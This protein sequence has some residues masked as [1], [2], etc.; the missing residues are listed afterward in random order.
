MCSS[1]L[2][3]RAHWGWSPCFETSPEFPGGWKTTAPYRMSR[4][5]T[6]RSMPPS[7]AHGLVTL[8]RDL[9]N[10]LEVLQ[11][12]VVMRDISFMTS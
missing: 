6:C 8:I 5:P 4:L 10:K 12:V 9:L 3:M 2:A 7:Q 11:Q 1:E